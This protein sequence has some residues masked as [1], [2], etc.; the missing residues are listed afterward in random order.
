MTVRSRY[1]GLSYGFGPGPLTPGV[2]ALIYANVAAFLVALVYR[3]IVL[4]FGLMPMAVLERGLIW[5]PFTYL[6]M[7]AG[8]GHILVNMLGLWMFGT[9]L[10]RMWRTRGFLKYY[11]V[12][13]VGAALLT[14]ALSFLPFGPFREMYHSLTIGA[15]GAIYGLLLAYG[16]SF[17]DRPIFVYAIFPVPAK[18]LVMIYGAVAF[19][20]SISDVGG[21]TAHLAHLGGLVIGYLYLRGGRID[22]TGEIKYRYWKWKTAR[23]RKR[24]DVY[25]GGRKDWDRNVH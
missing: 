19:V 1:S 13:G 7:H 5:Q 11:F 15:S 10:E 12:T 24:F 22:P 2:K 9:D 6:F 17:P 20:S 14:I 21:S 25:S 4:V 8:L 3:R 18:Y 23:M 16:L